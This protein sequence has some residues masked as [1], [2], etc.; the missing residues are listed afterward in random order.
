VSTATFVPET[1][2]LDGDD[3]LS[4][5]RH[6]GTGSVVARSLQRFRAADGFSHARSLGFL[7]ALILVQGLIALVGFATAF[8][9]RR[10]AGVVA[11]AIEGVVPSPAG[12]TLR[13]SVEQA[14]ST[15]ASHRY[16]ALVVGLLGA[17]LTGATAFGQI[18]RGANRIYGIEKDRPT[19][20]KYGLA[21]LLTITAGAASAASFFL[22]AVGSEVGDA[23]E[24][25]TAGQVWRVA[26]WPLGVLLLVAAATAIFRWSPRRHQPQASWMVVG[27]LVT[28][29]VWVVA[30][31]AMSAFLRNSAQ[32]GETYGPL[33]G[34]VALLFWSFFSGIAV[35]LGVAVAAQLEAE[36]VG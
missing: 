26:R 34:I 6:A 4:T 35:F 22:L 10:V 12:Q 21:L 2:E 32:F 33:A 28:V 17:I 36:R 24:S 5:L 3:A 18:E 14:T 9:E 16:T 27:G 20:E 15:G 30:S 29:A 1:H 23:I 11:R 31:V 8:G 25:D 7:I 19:A 13:A